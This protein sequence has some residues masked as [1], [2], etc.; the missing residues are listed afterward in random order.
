MRPNFLLS[1]KVN[2]PGTP[3]LIQFPVR[4]PHKVKATV[5]TI[6]VG[7]Y[8]EGGR[9]KEREKDRERERE[10]ER[11]KE[12][13]REA[14]TSSQFS[15]DTEPPSQSSSPASHSTEKPSSS[16][17]PTEASSVLDSE[18]TNKECPTKEV[19]GA[20]TLLFVK[21]KSNTN[22]PNLT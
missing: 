19:S 6:P 21:T 2:A 1:V 22:N 15:F 9:G 20:Q 8:E 10:K 3:K 16:D 18:N 11:E 12:K 4:T 7:S 17:R 14:A 13:E 5:A